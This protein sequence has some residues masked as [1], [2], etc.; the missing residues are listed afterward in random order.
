MRIGK[1]ELEKL[2]LCNLPQKAANVFAT[3]TGGLTKASY[4]PVFYVGKQEEED[5]TNYC[6]IALQTLVKPDGAKRLVRMVIKDGLDGQ[7]TLVSVRGLSI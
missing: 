7:A 5:G 4:E 1:W 2:K 3:V 6:I